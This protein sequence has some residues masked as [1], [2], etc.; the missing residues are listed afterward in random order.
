MNAGKRDMKR[1]IT[2]T[3]KKL[4]VK[5]KKR[6]L[7]KHKQLEIEVKLEVKGLQKVRREILA[8]G[9]EEKVHRAFEDNWILDFPKRSLYQNSCLLRLRE[10]NA[11][12]WVTFKGPTENSA[13]FKVREE[14]ETEV[15]DKSTLY[16]ILGRLGLRRAFRY[17]KYRSIFEPEAAQG[18][19]RVT[20]VLDET[21]IGNYLEIEGS[22]N[23]INTIAAR[24]GYSHQDFIRESYAD[25]YAKL[26]PSAKSPGMI[27][28]R[29]R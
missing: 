19:G 8:L 2:V 5:E 1:V 26:Y 21:P 18:L 22:P 12:C 13:H 9:F 6:Q 11:K 3:G 16:K 27:F 15:A 7:T 24:L 20:L 10:F 14:L 4:S 25:L 17:Q 29:P 23:E 28:R